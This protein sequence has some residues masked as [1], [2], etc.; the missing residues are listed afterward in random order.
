MTLSSSAPQ[1]EPIVITGMGLITALGQDVP[2]NWSAVLTRR[3]GIAPLPGINFAGAA[4]KGGGVAPDLADP[5]PRH[6]KPTIRGERAVRYLIHCIREAMGQAG[7]LAENPYPARRRAMMIGTTLGGM[8]SARPFVHSYNERGAPRARY[9]RL[10]AWNAG[11]VLRPLLDEFQFSGLGSTPTTACASGLSGIGLGATLLQSGR[12]DVALAGGYD[13]ISD[14]TYAGFNS[15]MLVD[16]GAIRP[17]DRDRRGLKVG[18]GYGLVVLER[19]SS[20]RARGAKA[21]ATILGYGETSDAYHLTRPIPDGAGA[22]LA[23]RLALDSAGLS[24]EDIDHVN[25]HGTATPDNDISEY[26]AMRNVFG[27]RLRDIPVTAVKSYMGHT[28]GGAGGVETVLTALS[29]M[30]NCVPATLN[31]EKVDPEMP[32]LDL[33]LDGPRK[34]QV[35]VAM[36]NSFGFGGCN[37]SLILGGGD[38]C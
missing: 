16:P 35:N 19:L 22:A 25:A 11:S 6:L 5:P 20:A 21:L 1:R 17:F 26:R 33:V 15:L 4:D 29:I 13:P 10:R 23:M 31:T 28:L 38:G 30:H 18:E 34:M 12:F 24:P 2:S 27:E 3:S 32:D 9:N 14:Y 37:A 36:T 8:I 7:L